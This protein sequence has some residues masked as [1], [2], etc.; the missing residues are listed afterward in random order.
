MNCSLVKTKNIQKTAFILALLLLTQ[1]GGKNA[2]NSETSTESETGK[3]AVLELLRVASPDPALARPSAMLGIFTTKFLALSELLGANSALR[4]IGAQEQFLADAEV[5]LEETYALLQELGNILQIDVPDMLNR[6]ENRAEALNTYV[7]NLKSAGERSVTKKES[8]ESLI[9]GLKVEQRAQRKTTTDLER[10]INKAVR[11]K[12][13]ATAGGEQQHL[14]EEQTKLSDIDRK[15]DQAKEILD[16]YE[17]LLKVAD[18]RLS[19]IEHNREV[20]I[21]GLKVVELP[22]VDDLGILEEK[23][24]REVESP[25]GL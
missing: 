17:D 13:Y 2:K 8:L 25:L 18:E 22:G 20:L 10:Q 7:A 24:R 6:S 11:D 21:A 16:T 4:G 19:V 12:D 3:I 9:D 14:I 5:D 15:L 23:R 1:C